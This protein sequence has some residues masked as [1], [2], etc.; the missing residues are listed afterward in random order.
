MGTL[1]ASQLD[2]TVCAGS[3]RTAQ[4]YPDHR[5]LTM[6]KERQNTRLLH[7]AHTHTH[8]PLVQR[9]EAHRR[10]A[11]ITPRVGWRLSHE[12]THQHKPHGD[13]PRSYR[14]D[15]SVCCQYQQCRERCKTVRLS[16]GKCTAYGPMSRLIAP[17]RDDRKSHV[18]GGTAFDGAPGQLTIQVARR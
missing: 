13:V 2:A 10:S 18:Q 14:V 5:V 7:S 1:G 16:Q 17:S 8:R 12:A 4:L 15:P 11:S 9:P 3:M 6:S